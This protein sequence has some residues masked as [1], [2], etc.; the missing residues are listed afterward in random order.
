MKIA[1]LHNGDRLEFPDETPD[2]VMDQT[3][4][5][6]LM[7]LQPPQQP[8]LGAQALEGIMET[9]LHVIP[10][11]VE[12]LAQYHQATANSG[13]Q[14]VQ[15]I[16]GMNQAVHALAKNTPETVKAINNLSNTLTDCTQ[17][18]LKFLALRR[19]IIHSPDKT[20]IGIQTVQQLM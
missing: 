9:L 14:L 8:D 20:P 7:E 5:N 6:H 3:V 12:E 10:N 1:E 13:A 4:R 18:L 15:L 19:E 17:T 2:E 11:A 16:T